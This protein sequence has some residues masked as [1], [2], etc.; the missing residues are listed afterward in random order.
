VT[1]LCVPI[2]VTDDLAKSGRDIATAIEAGAEMIELRIDR[3]EDTEYF[4]PLLLHQPIPMIV[5][6]RPTWEGGQSELRDDTRLPLLAFAAEANPQN[7]IDIELKSIRGHEHIAVG[8]LREFTTD[9]RGGLIVSYHDFSSRPER[10]YNLVTEM[11]RL[12]AH[13][14]KLVWQ[15]RSV[16]DNVE[17]LEMLVHRQRPTV[18]LCMGEAGIPSRVL[19]KKFGAFLTFASLRT[20]EATAPGQVTIDDMKN[21]YRWEAIGPQTKVYGVV[22]SPVA[23]S[24][25]PAIHNAAFDAAEHDGVYLPLLVEPGYESFKAFMESFLHFEKLDL[26]GLSV[27]IPHKENALRYLTEKGATI[28]PLA[29][30]IGAV[31][32]I[33]IDKGHLTG[34]NTDHAAILECICRAAGIDRAGLSAL[35]IAIIGAG[36][37]GRTAVASLAHFGATVLVYNRTPERAQRLAAEFNGHAGKV[38][39]VPLEQLDGCDIWM[40]CSSVG[41]YP[42]SD[43]NPLGDFKPNWSDKTIVFDAVYNPVK[44]KFL[45]QAEAAGA[46]TITGVEMFIRQAATQFETWT[47][48]SAPLDVMRNVVMKRLG[49]ETRNQKPE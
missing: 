34:S 33:A 42:K 35:K 6:C 7:F 26:A 29:Q 46:K 19:A 23:H 20:G 18:A 27:T 31:N 15:A 1:Y 45:Q 40:N 41:M 37:T 21:L 28:E 10:M 3:L 8:L 32:T 44:T 9:V 25:S 14:N 17:A 12:P 24:M 30:S 4:E 11:N 39:A 43:A 48:K 5:T 13:V 47:R 49:A 16:R 22:A 36:G 38:S 2:F